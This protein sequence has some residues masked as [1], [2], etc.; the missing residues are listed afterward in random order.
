MLFIE[1]TKKRNARD[2]SCRHTEIMWRE[3]G[4]FVDVDHDSSGPRENENQIGSCLGV[5][6]EEFGPAGTELGGQGSAATAPLP[7]LLP[8]QKRVS[9][10]GDTRTAIPD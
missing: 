6:L 5:I 10:G 3:K 7:W 4:R 2:R 8:P 9:N 1:Q